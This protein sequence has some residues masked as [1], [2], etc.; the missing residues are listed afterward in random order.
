MSHYWTALVHCWVDLACN[1]ALLL[2]CRH[3]VAVESSLDQF[4]YFSSL[5]LFWLNNL[6]NFFVCKKTA[7]RCSWVFTLGWTYPALSA[8]LHVSSIPAFWLAWWPLSGGPKL[9]TVLQRWLHLCQGTPN[10]RN[11]DLQTV[12]LIMHPVRGWVS[13]LPQHTAACHWVLLKGC[14]PLLQAPLQPVSPRLIL[15]PEVVLQHSARNIMRFLSVHLSGL[16]R[17]PASSS[18]FFKTEMQDMGLL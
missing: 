7:I 6:F 1:K 12:P 18:V 14:S 16:S 15:M 10:W 4:C 3:F 13:L 11:L 9:G 8:S 2:L 5:G 17:F